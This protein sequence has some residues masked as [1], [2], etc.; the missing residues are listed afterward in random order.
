MSDPS[1]QTAYLYD[2]LNR[3]TNKT[4]AWNGGPTLALNYRYNPTGSITNIRSST[5]GGVNLVYAYDSL[6]RLTNALANGSA[7]A[8][9]G[10]DAV[11]NLQ[12]VTYGNGVTNLYQYDT[13]NRMTSAAW[14]KNATGLGS[15][16]YHLGPTGS[17]TNLGETVS[18]TSRSYAW[19]YDRLYRLTQEVLNG[20]GGGTVA[21]GYDP[22][23]NRT[24]RQ[25]TISQLP[26]SSST[27]TAND[28]LTA[29]TYD[30]NGN[31]TVS[32]ANSYEYDALNR[33]TNVNSGAVLISYDGDG[34]RVRKTVSATA[35]TTYSLVDDRNP[36]GYAQVLEEYQSVSGATP[37][38]SRVYTYG[39]ALVSPHIPERVWQEPLPGVFCSK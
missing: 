1:G 14:N 26:S 13:R 7:A 15:F 10:F 33:L 5:A 38:V 32:S 23:G 12:S 30:A 17:R 34:N 27:Y 28:W 4:V 2:D 19:T 29:D 35:T 37:A 31:T 11:G 36:S 24:N 20:S 25:S 18:G 6:R 39:L 9:Y 21:Y 8:G 22:V 16:T 3:L